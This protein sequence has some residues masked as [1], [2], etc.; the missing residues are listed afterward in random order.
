MSGGIN[1]P[2]PAGATVTAGAGQQCAEAFGLLTAIMAAL[3]ASHDRHG[4][5]SRGS[6]RPFIYNTFGGSGMLRSRIGYS[7]S[8]GQRIA[9]PAT[10]A[11]S[12]SAFGFG[13]G[14]M[15]GGA[16]LLGLYSPDAFYRCAGRSTTP[17]TPTSASPVALIS[18]RERIEPIPGAR[19]SCSQ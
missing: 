12:S 16:D 10:F 17:S 15:Q 14:V 1:A 19:D 8:S 13:S 2:G 7:S 6:R 18:R 11:R 9:M 3:T 5:R 4:I